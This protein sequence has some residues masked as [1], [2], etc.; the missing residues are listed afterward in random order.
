MSRWIA[1]GETIL[2][3]LI[4]VL[5]G[6][7]PDRLTKCLKWYVDGPARVTLEWIDSRRDRLADIG[8]LSEIVSR[9]AADMRRRWRV[10]FGEPHMAR[11]FLEALQR[12]TLRTKQF[13]DLA[14]KI[15]VFH[16]VSSVPI[17]DEPVGRP[18][19]LADWARM[20]EEIRRALHVIRSAGWTLSL[21]NQ[22]HQRE[23]DQRGQ[24][25]REYVKGLLSYAR[26]LLDSPVVN[27]PELG[28]TVF[29]DQELELGLAR[30]RHSL[31]GLERELL[32]P[33]AKPGGG[34]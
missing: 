2:S 14:G 16:R 10:T 1:Y 26:E 31:S 5:E 9:A 25:P 28:N 18:S 23:M 11:R 15:D 32:G 22:M 12:D 34:G 6:P 33:P 4:L 20:S 19:C 8:G 13:A 21:V 27:Q 24:V 29:C 7:Q 30:T 17:F 3:P